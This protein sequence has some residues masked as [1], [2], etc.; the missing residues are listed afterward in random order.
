MDQ[1]GSAT[2]Q[3]G[4]ISLSSGLAA[5][6]TGSGFGLPLGKMGLHPSLLGFGAILGRAD[7]VS[8]FNEIF[9]VV[10]GGGPLGKEAA[11]AGWQGESILG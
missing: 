1:F 11:V 6:W 2:T 7:D 10:L 4:L 9:G 8:W 3:V 5:T